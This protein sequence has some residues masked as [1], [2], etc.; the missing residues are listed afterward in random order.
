M[1]ICE[2]EAVYIKFRDERYMVIKRKIKTFKAWLS[3]RKAHL[4]TRND[5]AIDTLCGVRYMMVYIIPTSI[6]SIDLANSEADLLIK[7]STFT[8]LTRLYD[9][10]GYRDCLVSFRHLRVGDDI[11]DVCLERIGITTK[12]HRGCAAKP[13][14]LLR[15]RG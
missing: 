8:G 2:A 6:K 7:V 9:D 15:F 14:P 3:D 4:S 11:C 5:L 10:S 12:N 1:R 13:L